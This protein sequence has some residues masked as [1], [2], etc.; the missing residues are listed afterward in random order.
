MINQ[1]TKFSRLAAVFL[2]LSLMVLSS[3]STKSA[4]SGKS[5]LTVDNKI[6]HLPKPIPLKGV[7]LKLEVMGL[8]DGFCV[9]SLFFFKTYGASNT[10]K[11][12]NKKTF[13]HCGDLFSEGNGPNEYQNLS[14]TG[15]YESS[16]D[17]IRLW[18]SDNIIKKIRLINITKSLKQKTIV[19]EKEYS[20]KGS[21]YNS[22]CINDSSFVTTYYYWKNLSFS[23]Y[24]PVSKVRT[25]K[26]DFFNQT[27]TQDDLFYISGNPALKPDKTKLAYAMI[28]LNQVLI[29]SVDG[30]HKFSISI[31][32]PQSKSE[33]DE[34]SRGN[35]IESFAMIAADDKHI[36]L[37]Y[38]GET[39]KILE[40]DISKAA[41]S[42]LIVLDWDGKLAYCF[43]LETN[44]G[45]MFIDTND[46]IL[47]GIDRNEGIIKYDISKYSK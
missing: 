47:Y 36:W 1:L 2:I 22:Y 15:Q 31:G 6:I 45:N 42:K 39:R 25:D 43:T 24:N 19:P 21:L 28:N 9:D 10:F 14:S 20:Y 8:F 40:S 16:P 34:T 26:F 11:I 32:S 18:V 30:T 7:K 44:I 27:M 3:C 13:A 46:K 41:P 23:T 38:Q 33:V 17:G 12:Y 29:T 4:H 37:L 5:F 35:R